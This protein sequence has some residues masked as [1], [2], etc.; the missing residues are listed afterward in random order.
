M[1]NAGEL[2]GALDQGR[3]E[4]INL[5]VIA[6]PRFSNGCEFECL[7]DQVSGKLVDILLICTEL[8]AM[9]GSISWSRSCGIS[10]LEGYSPVRLR[11]GEFSILGQL[12]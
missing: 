2:C 11:P 4:F 5:C 7:I 10:G 3:K 9:G 6:R 1:L 8:R 12:M